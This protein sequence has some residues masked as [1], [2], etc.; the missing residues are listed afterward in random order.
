M[1]KLINKDFLK[2]KLYEFPCLDHEPH[3]FRAIFEFN[4]DALIYLSSS[5]NNKSVIAIH[6]KAGKGRTGLMICCLLVFLGFKFINKDKELPS[7]EEELN[8]LDI[9]EEIYKIP[10]LESNIN[11]KDKVDYAIEIY[12][13]SLEHL[14][15]YWDKIVK[16]FGK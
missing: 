8:E 9:P 10:G 4:I 5:S 3:K 12:F 2:Y 15:K 14:L 11:N 16:Y 7:E 1:T 6:C 13:N